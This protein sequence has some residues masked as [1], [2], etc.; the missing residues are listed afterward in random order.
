MLYRLGVVISVG[1]RYTGDLK[2]LFSANR[3]TVLETDYLG[4]SKDE[5]QKILSD[6]YNDTSRALGMSVHELEL[7]CEEVFQAFRPKA[8]KAER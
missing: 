7:H 4:S 1:P 8:V 5:H 3:M 6:H 2:S